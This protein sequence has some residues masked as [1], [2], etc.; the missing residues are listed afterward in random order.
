M[1]NYWPFGIFLLAMVVVGLI[2]LTL[3]VAITNPVELQGMCQLSAQYIDENSNAITQMRN[4]LLSQYSFSFEGRLDPK[5]EAFK[6]L[7]L[8]IQT[9]DGQQVSGDVKVQF[10]L[11]RP[12]TNKENKNLGYGDFTNHLWQSASFDVEK[13]GRYQSEALVQI[14]ADSICVVQEYFVR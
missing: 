13:K 1:K 10:F 11:T 7:F 4:R 14:G 12:N 3:K 2:T 5:K 6:R 8:K 9:K